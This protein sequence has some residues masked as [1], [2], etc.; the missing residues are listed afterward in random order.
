MLDEQAEK[1]TQ[2]ESLKNTSKTTP[3]ENKIISNLLNLETA[4]EKNVY[5]NT[6][7]IKGIISTKGAS[8][9]DWKLKKYKM[10]D[11]KDVEMIPHN[12]DV[13]GNLSLI[14]TTVDTTIDTKDFI[15]E[16]NKDSVLINKTDS[17]GVTFTLNLGDGKKIIKKYTF[18]DDEYNFELEVILE[19]LGNIISDREYSIAW[20]SG[21]AS[22]EKRL[23]DDMFY[24]KAYISA[25]GNTEQFKKAD[26]KVHNISG[27][28]IDW[29]ALRTKYFV[30]AI[31]PTNEKGLDATIKG[32]EIP[33]ANKSEKWKKF[34]VE[35]SLPFL[36]DR[37]E[38]NKFLIYCGPLDY[39]IIKKYGLG[40][41]SMMDFGWKIIE[42]FSKIVLWS[43][44]KIHTVI[45]NYGL[46]L[47]IFSILIKII[48]YPLTAKS[49]NSMQRMQALQPKLS[50]LKEK[51][52]KD[53]QR[54]NQETMKLYKQFGVN[55]LGGCLPV[56][57]QMPL[58]Y[59]LFIIFRTTIELRGQGFIWWIKDLSNPDTVYTLPFSIPIYGN[60]VNIL[61]L[62]MGASMLLQQKMGMQDPKQKMMAYMMPIFFTLLFNNFPSG[63]TLYYTLFNVLTIV[64][65][66]ITS[67]NQQVELV[68]VKKPRS[69][70]E[71]LYQRK[72]R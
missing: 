32:E 40:F 52:G 11:K 68:P 58:L 21:L 48:V 35:L 37:Y 26:D 5:V 42:P 14:F 61:P 18:Y 3:K 65:Q 31:A 49:Y 43:L 23:N 59:A 29:V 62:L 47:I 56:I 28:K 51:Y 33:T 24:S 63:L 44:K 54:L 41:E 22:T 38:D 10:W 27:S 4:T 45:S 50:E 1:V 39:D 60:D 19:N 12:S 46:V 55:P 2:K 15:F 70:R 7:L 64:Q 72:R 34:R 13:Y 71:Y 17:N 53:P 36:N 69:K 66:K 8:L 30:T 25:A 16:S 6:P 9:V 67:K 57:I 20:E